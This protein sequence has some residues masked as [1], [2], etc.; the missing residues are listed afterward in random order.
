MK[1]ADF[2]LG[3]FIFLLNVKISLRIY[4]CVLLLRRNEY[5]LCDWHEGSK[6]HGCENYYEES[7]CD[8]KSSF[9]KFLSA[10]FVWDLKHECEGDRTSDHASV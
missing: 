3:H 8:N 9:F 2:F 5:L 10:C 7:S 1:I 6:K 4:M